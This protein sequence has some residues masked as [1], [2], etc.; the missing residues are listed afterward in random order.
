MKRFARQA[1]SGRVETPNMENGCSIPRGRLIKWAPI[2]SPCAR[3]FVNS[4][5]KLSVIEKLF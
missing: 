2:D 1:A 5:S 3:G 4:E